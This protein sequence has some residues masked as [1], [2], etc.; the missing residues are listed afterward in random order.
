MNAELT[1]RPLR[2]SILTPV[3]NGS[4]FLEELINSVLQQDYAHYEHIIIDDGSNDNGSTVNI[5]RRY[6]HLKWKSQNNLGQYPTQNK[7][8]KMASGDVISIICADDLYP[9]STVFSSVARRFAAQPTLDAVIGRTI[10]LAERDRRWYVF[11]PDL[12][13]FLAKRLIRYSV[14]IQHCAMFVRR[15]VVEEKNLYFDPYYKLCGDWDWIIRVLA[16][17]TEVAYTNEVLAYWRLHER[18]SPRESQWHDN[19]ARRV[20]AVYQTSYDLHR[21]VKGCVNILG[22]MCAKYEQVKQLG[23]VSTM[24]VVIQNVRRR[25]FG[26]AD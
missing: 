24:R 7:L 15:R 25:S 26:S 2:F 4:E 13:A 18:H 21:V 19:E 22:M 8:L 10:R 20:C 6:P 5:L 17:S 1:D 16:A 3:Y 12:P 9:A 14:G 23:L 11:D